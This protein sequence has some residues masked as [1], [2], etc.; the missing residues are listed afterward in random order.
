MKKLIAL[1]AIA[2]FVVG[3]SKNDDREMLQE[4]EARVIDHAN[5]VPVDDEI[6][7]VLD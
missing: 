6:R 2:L 1:V 5:D 4:P 3:C 7:V